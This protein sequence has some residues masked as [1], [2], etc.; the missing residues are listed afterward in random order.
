MS[1]VIQILIYLWKKFKCLIRSTAE[2]IV[3]IF[4]PFSLAGC[5][6]MIMD[7]AKKADATGDTYGK[8][9]ETLALPTRSNG[10]L[11]IY[12]TPNST[13]YS[14]QYGIGLQKN[15]TYC[16]IDDS[17]YELIWETFKYFDLAEGSH[18]ISCGKDVL[19]KVEFWSGKIKFQQGK[20]KLK[21]M[22]LNSSEVFVRVDGTIES[23][24]FQ[25]VL[26]NSEQG[27]KEIFNLPYQKAAFNIPDGKITE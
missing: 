18:E 2:L 23:P 3:I 1:K 9:K 17:A 19:K 21:V 12:R 22:I 25:P 13:N 20:N 15:T 27:N 26:V 11:Y 10:R 8:M 14:I 24:Y 16:T 5:A 4:L 6:G 7:A